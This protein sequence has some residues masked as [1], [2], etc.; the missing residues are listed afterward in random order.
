[1]ICEHLDTCALI[2]QMVKSVP[3]TINMMKI[4]YCEF[5]KCRC[6]R[7][8]LSQVCGMEEIPVT[9]WPGDEMRGLEL[10]EAKLNETR[11]KLYGCPGEAIPV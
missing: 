3:F 10:L 9:L 2:R 7:Y 1:M 4:K 11:N 5:N 6:V 8:K